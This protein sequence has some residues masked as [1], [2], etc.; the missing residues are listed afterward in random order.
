[1]PEYCSSST[2]SDSESSTHTAYFLRSLRRLS[3]HSEVSGE[4]PRAKW[5][6]AGFVVVKLRGNGNTPTRPPYAQ[7]LCATTD[8]CPGTTGPKGVAAANCSGRLRW[9]PNPLRSR[10]WGVLIVW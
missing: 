8:L 3:A 5:D 10:P 1:V 9:S 6:F 4:D 2:Q 7:L